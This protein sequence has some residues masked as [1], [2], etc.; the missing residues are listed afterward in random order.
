MSK[1][2]TNT[3]VFLDGHVRYFLHFLRGNQN[4]NKIGSQMLRIF[5]NIFFSNS[6][7]K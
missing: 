3:F 7:G 1:T 2:K 5:I 4:E 6:F